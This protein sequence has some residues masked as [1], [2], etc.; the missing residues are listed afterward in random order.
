MAVVTKKG[1]RRKGPKPAQIAR[2]WDDGQESLDLYLKD[3]S[4]IPLLKIDEEKAL[5]RKA[6]KGDKRAQEEL[7]RRNVR[8]VVS[9]A[10][11][12]QNRGVPLMDLIGEGNLGLLTAARKFD[13]ERGVKFI[14]YAVWWV[15]Q[16]IQAAIARHGRAV[17]LPLNRTADANRLARATTAL[18]ERLGR[19]P[20]L[21][22]LVVATRLTVETVQSLS[23]LQFEPLRLDR[24]V[25]EGD[26]TE[27]M[28]R[29]MALTEEGTDASTL[30]N[31]R[32][33]EL[34][35]ALDQLPARD[36]KVIRLYFGL[37]DDEPRTLEQI[38]RLL[39]VT[40]ERVRQLRD[41]ALKTLREQHG[42]ALRELAA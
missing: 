36:A 9:V 38:G 23:A 42:D 21:E 40:R 24:P 12:Y 22:E 1:G 11:Q 18:K 13:P 32:T 5:G 25:R 37:D 16:A 8:F 28:E 17:R 19:H 15:R 41:R 39:G 3:I 31:N 34:Y 33:E 29:F 14:S 7:A 6:F 4:K 10:K 35:A 30:E 27:R 20:T 2:E 26:S